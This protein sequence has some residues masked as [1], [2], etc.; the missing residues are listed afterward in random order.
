MSFESPNGKG[1][2]EFVYTT[3]EA[4][5]IV[6]DVWDGWLQKQQEGKPSSAAFQLPASVGVACYSS[7]FSNMFY[8]N[9]RTD[10]LPPF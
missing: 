2:M 7:P 4:R 6:F 9:A 8:H 1:P 5:L 10:S 3:S